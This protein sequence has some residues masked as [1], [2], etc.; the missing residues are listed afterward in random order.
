LSAP[1]QLL[2]AIE[3]GGTRVRFALGSATSIRERAELSTTTPRALVEAA[4]SFFGK[5]AVAALG[6]AAF[7]P[8]DVDPVSKDCGTLLETPK[9]GWSRFPLLAELAA[10]LRRPI[11]VETDVNAAA[12]AEQRA[13]P[14]ATTLVYV[15]VGTGIGVGVALSG[16]AH[17]GA[18]HPEG[19]HLRV[20][21]DPKD[22]FPG[23]CPFHRGC[24]E[25][26]ASGAALAARARVDPATLPSTHELFELEAGYLAQLAVDVV[27]L[28]APQRIVLGGGVMRTERLLERVRARA[29]ALANGYSPLLA[30]AA[31]A[32]QLL[33]APA[34]GED[35]ALL[36]A[37][38]GAAA[39]ALR[40]EGS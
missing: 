13:Y 33:V 4:A 12:L 37:L 2:G 7:G 1:T 23:T 35:S 17:H 10:A 18:L 8:I 36:G 30:D 22:D 25:G 19:G 24:L 15:T 20:E 9:P 26:L 32:E 16:R 11:H 14:D 29:T 21:R 39:L 40:K 28:L 27:A 6:V 34:L 31:R 38:Q 3:T 5:H